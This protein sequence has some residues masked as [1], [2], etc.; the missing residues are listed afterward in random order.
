[1]R[2]KD[3][4]QKGFVMVTALIFL[5]V[6]TLLAITAVRRATQDES[7]AKSVREQNI[8]FEAAETALRW[9]QKELEQTNGGSELGT[10]VVQTVNGVPV[11]LYPESLAADP[12]PMPNLWKTRANWTS[13]GYRL[14]TN[15]VPNVSAQPQCMIE[16]WKKPNKKFGIVDANSAGNGLGKAYV[17][18][19]RAQGI[20]AASVIWLQVEVYFGSG[21]GSQ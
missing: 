9:C 2:Y 6:L 12:F 16:E 7:I 8:A 21:A 13:L 18:T 3:N 4:A 15:T 11:N 10:G 5:M 1:M 20:Y 19:A 17:I 14:P